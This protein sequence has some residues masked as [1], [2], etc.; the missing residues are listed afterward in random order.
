[1]HDLQ[2]LRT[3]GGGGRER[4]D[5]LSLHVRMSTNAAEMMKNCHIAGRVSG[6]AHD[7]T[8]APFRAVIYYVPSF[9]FSAWLRLFLLITC[10]PC[11][12]YHIY[13][14]GMSGFRVNAWWNLKRVCFVTPCWASAEAPTTRTTRKTF[15]VTFLP[16]YG[17]E[18]FLFFNLTFKK[19]WGKL[20]KLWHICEFDQSAYRFFMLL[21]FKFFHRWYITDIGFE[22]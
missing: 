3:P 16:L 8:W 12:K 6:V 13:Q 5:L 10:K 2:G 9:L 7:S 4:L 11:A 15:H 21:C 18:H 14:S 17:H 1:M 22:N 20:F 19:F